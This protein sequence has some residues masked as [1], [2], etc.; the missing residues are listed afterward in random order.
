[1]E[2]FPLGFLQG[3]AA[4]EKFA[5]LKFHHL[6][7]VLQWPGGLLEQMPTKPMEVAVPHRCLAIIPQQNKIRPEKSSF[8]TKE[9]PVE[10]G[11]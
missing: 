3:G 11:Q 4:W 8:P 6:Q 9:T 2:S 5:V 1:M 7:L 10:E